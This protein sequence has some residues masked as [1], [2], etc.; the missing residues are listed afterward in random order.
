[1]DGV[2]EAK[3]DQRGFGLVPS[4]PGWFV[5][6]LLDAYWETHAFGDACFFENP[7]APFEQL[8]FSVRVLWP[9]RST[10]LYHA[11]S[12]QEAFLVVAGEALLIVEDVERRLRAWDF[13]HCPARTRHAFVAIGRAPC[14]IVMAGSRP[15][16]HSYRYP[17]SPIAVERGVAAT[18]ET[19]AP[20]EALSSFEPWTAI[21]A[22]S[23]GL[24]WADPVE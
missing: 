3:L 23:D 14:V 2:Q 5:V 6:S 15:A 7:D 17:R 16:Q 18:V 9:G 12:A 24:P 10:W 1:M 13:V 20:E 21:P 19:T 4:T 11:E 8:G 22:P